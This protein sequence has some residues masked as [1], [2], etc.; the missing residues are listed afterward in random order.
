MD[1][2]LH[3]SKH[4]KVNR[5]TQRN[6]VAAVIIYS[7]SMAVMPGLLSVHISFQH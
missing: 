7:L 2:G 3:L 1:L 5:R 6:Q 4:S